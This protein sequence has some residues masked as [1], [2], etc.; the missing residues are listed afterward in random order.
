MFVQGEYGKGTMFY[1]LV[2]MNGEGSNHCRDSSRDCV[3]ADVGGLR[4]YSEKVVFEINEKTW[5]WNTVYIL[6]YCQFWGHSLQLSQKWCLLNI[7]KNSTKGI[8][9]G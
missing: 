5:Q 2:P 1:P 6:A 9:T 8:D 7:I 3:A 4:D